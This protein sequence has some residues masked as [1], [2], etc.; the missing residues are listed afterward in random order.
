[1]DYM[2]DNREVNIDS[3]YEEV[4]LVSTGDVTKRSESVV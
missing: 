3:R 2:G 4:G 1:M